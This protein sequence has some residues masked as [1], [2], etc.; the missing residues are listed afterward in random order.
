[1]LTEYHKVLNASDVRDVLSLMY[2]CGMYN[3]RSVAHTF[4]ARHSRGSGDQWRFLICQRVTIIVY[5]NIY[6][7]YDPS[8]AE[9]SRSR[10]VCRPSPGCRAPSSWW[11]PT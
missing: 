3:Y 6:L 4:S 10:L 8:A 2:S 7:I 5:D 9:S 11:C 1:M